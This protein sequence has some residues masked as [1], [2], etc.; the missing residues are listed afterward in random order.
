MGV[1]SMGC[2]LTVAGVGAPGGSVITENTTPVPAMCN[3]I[4]GF[5]GGLERTVDG[6]GVPKK[7]RV[8]HTDG[9]QGRH[10][11]NKQGEDSSNLALEAE[12]N[13]K[14]VGTGLYNTNLFQS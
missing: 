9:L 12:T 14:H 8:E 10:I 4:E 11:G 3:N 2:E 13:S 6:T 1:S 5:T 7:K